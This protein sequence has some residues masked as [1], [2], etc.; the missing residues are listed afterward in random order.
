MVVL[1]AWSKVVTFL[2]LGSGRAQNVAR[3][4]VGVRGKVATGVEFLG[5]LMEVAWGK[6]TLV[7]SRQGWRRARFPGSRCWGW[8]EWCEIG[9]VETRL[10]CRRGIPRTGKAM[11]GVEV[12]GRVR[13]L[14]RGLVLGE[15][16]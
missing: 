8:D 1:V 13:C 15:T 5:T 11:V 3:L 9:G 7:L 2:V 16:G 6:A 14:V 4:I 10:M 12:V